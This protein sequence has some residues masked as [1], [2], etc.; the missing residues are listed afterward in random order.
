MFEGPTGKKMMIRQGYVPPMCTLDEEIAG[1][2]IFREIS[3][4]HSPC[5]GCT[6]DR[7]V[8]RGQPKGI[9]TP[10]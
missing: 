2:L 7:N 9:D 10:G 8:C 3:A 4:G 6:M 5:Q 1:P